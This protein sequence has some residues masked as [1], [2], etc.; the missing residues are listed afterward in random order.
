MAEA[1][2]GPAAQ[3]RLPLG[4][5]A[6]AVWTCV[7][8]WFV[9]QGSDLLWVVALGDVTRSGGGVPTSLPFASAPQAE[10]HNPIV[11]A[12]LLLS[13]VHAL[14][15]AGL[16]ALQ[17]VVVAVT[18]VVLLAEGRRLGGSEGR[19]ALVLSLVVVGA[20]AHLVITR[21]PSLSLVPYVL[22]LAVMRRQ[23]DRPSLAVWWLVP[24]YLVWGNLHGGVL[25][26]LAVLGVFL[27]A[28]PGGGPV[29]RRAG[30]GLG[31]ALTLV[32][33]SA[34]LRTPAYYVSA[35]GN[36]AAARGTDLWARPS[37]GQPLDVVMIVAAVVLVVLAVRARPPL[38]EWLAVAGLV[39]GA[40]S[41]GRNAV[42]LLL[43]LAP[44][45]MRM[46]VPARTAPAVTIR[47]AA[48]AVATVVVVAVAA[49][50]LVVRGP[51]V[52]AP[53]SAVVEAVRAAAGGR[54]VLASEPLAETLAQAG[55]T[56]W[57]A[58]PID[59]FP[60]DVQGQ[61]LDFLHDGTVP[62]EPAIGLV[63]VAA[64]AAAAVAAD[65]DWIPGP[66]LDGYVL[67]TPAP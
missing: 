1:V 14:G 10:W 43:F 45:A 9:I 18:L 64:D 65:G 17:L 22:A 37:L 61:F 2:R 36:E 59:A 44:A 29:L 62:D 58:N 16:A 34:G 48:A 47:P 30:V 31:C 23:H 63:V 12:E 7:L 24:I 50:A 15:P 42:W 39:L 4:L 26:G 5:V 67:L 46:R 49:T 51:A 21:L 33:T 19:C 28:S 55:V 38:W 41:A 20:S 6:V 60:R 54:P 57:A 35:L 52:E 3:R 66:P 32:L 53:G 8:A 25:V 27:V 40:A 11:L 56:V 13:L